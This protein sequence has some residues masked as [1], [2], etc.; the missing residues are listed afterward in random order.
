MPK[1]TLARAVRAFA[2]LAL[3]CAL[4]IFLGLPPSAERPPAPA[5]VGDSEQARTIAAMRP[6]KRA[7]PLIAVIGANDGTETTDYLIPYGVLKRSGVADVIGLSMAPGP[8]TLMPSLTILPEG[9]ASAFDRLHPDGADYV[10]VP[11]MFTRDESVIVDWIRSQAA[12]G[13][14]I[15][16]VCE[17]ARI[18]AKAGMLD[19]RRATSHWYAINGIKAAH[20]SLVYARDRRYVADRGVVTTTGVTASLPV[21]IA[22]V[23]AIAGRERA[24]ALAGDI[25]LSNWREDHNSEAFRLD[26]AAAST[27]LLN[28]LSLW[29]YRTLDFAIA[30]GVDEVSL[31]LVADAFSRTQMTNVIAVSKSSGPVISKDGLAI[32]T[33]ERNDHA[34]EANDLASM[35]RERPV[36]ALDKALSAISD[37]Y[38]RA[39]ADWVA[40]T[41]EYPRSG[42]AP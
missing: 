13:A 5:A 37:R 41:L 1:L 17:G 32:V 8:M 15:V 35:T 36:I 30:D 18:L 28:S 39:T 40:L 11:A 2:A 9:T 42:A 34:S 12:K 31:A 25:G 20:P 22:L 19:G 29:N 4:V 24:Q 6:P 3:V 26:R 27:Y 21:S 23:E 14:T 33:E 10:I 7:R 16:G 38:G